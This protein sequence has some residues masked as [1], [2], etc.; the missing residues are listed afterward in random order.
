MIDSHRSECTTVRFAVPSYSGTS[1]YCRPSFSLRTGYIWTHTC[2]FSAMSSHVA[3]LLR[4]ACSVHRR[5]V[6]EG[7]PVHMC[8]QSMNL[9]TKI[10]KPSTA[11]KGHRAGRRQHYE[12]PTTMAM[13]SL[14]V[15]YS[16]PILLGYCT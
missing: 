8:L 10:R 2:T 6:C 12:Y 5:V 4:F 7:T 14:I 16:R 1:A 11:C 9:T 3:D 13:R 15:V